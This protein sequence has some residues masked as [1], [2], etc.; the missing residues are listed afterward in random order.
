MKQPVQMGSLWLDPDTDPAVARVLNS[1]Y[2]DQFRIRVWYGYTTTGRAHLEEYDVLGRV[3]RSTG[4]WKVPLLVNNAR[5]LGG[6]VLPTH[7]IVR[8]DRTDTRETLYKHPTFK[9]G[10]EEYSI[11]QEG[12]HF[13]VRVGGARLASLDTVD[14]ARRWVAFMTGERYGK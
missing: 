11:G 8:I 12:D 9:H 6:P 10:F 7:C 2:N 3:G 5:A 1:A 4:E 14:G 13:V